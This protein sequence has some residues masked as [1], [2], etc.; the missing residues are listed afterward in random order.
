MR[1]QTSA[2]QSTTLLDDPDADELSL[3]GALTAVRQWRTEADGQHRLQ[4]DEIDGEVE[5][6]RIAI[7]DLQRQIDALADVRSRIMDKRRELDREE[8]QRSRDAVFSTLKAQADALAARA[9]V[10]AEGNTERW[11]KVDAELAEPKLAALAEEVAQFQSTRDQ[12]AAI[13]ASYRGVLLAHHE[14]QVAQ[15]REAVRALD[16]G[17][18]QL[19]L[20]P[21]ELTVAYTVD[22][23]EGQPEL[24]S[25]ILPVR[26]EI[27]AQWGNHG[28]DL[29]LLTAARVVQ[30]LYEA[31][32]SIGLVTNQ[33]MHGGH[34]GL[35]AVEMEVGGDHGQDTAGLI[36]V[37]INHVLAGAP[38]LQAAGVRLRA[39]QLP[40]DYLLPADDAEEGD[41][42]R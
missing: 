27:Y 6:L 37:S 30:G 1:P 13:P 14:A 17:P 42:A 19:P 41:D 32:C 8:G 21:L 31:C 16:P 36:A 33:A 23:A 18:T 40:T 35:L 26:E 15:L 24:V 38:E 20:A 29:R 5:R 9:A 3:D 11:A 39:L 2:M 4:I 7:A 34:E 28:D 10:A 22:A 25:L 12:L